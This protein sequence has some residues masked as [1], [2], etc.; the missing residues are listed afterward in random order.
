MKSK[1]LL[2]PI[3]T[4]KSLDV[5]EKENKIV[6]AVGDKATNQQIRDEVEKAYKVKVDSINVLNSFGKGKK[7]FIKLKPDFEAGKIVSDMGLM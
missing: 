7:A 4:E 3:L 5:L 2:Y 1:I 6:F